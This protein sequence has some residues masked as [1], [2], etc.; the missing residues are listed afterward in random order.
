MLF[1]QGNNMNL[2]VLWVGF[3][4]IFGLP[5]CYA[6][7]DERDVSA[8]NSFYAALGSPPLPGWILNG[9]DP[10]VENWQ[11]VQCV[12]P[13]ITAIVIN[14]ANLG[15]QLGDGLGNFSSIIT[16]DL[17]NNNIGGDIPESLPLTLRTFFLSANQFTGSIPSSLSNLTLLT[18]MS[19]N[20]N[21]LTGDLPDAFSSL[22]GLINLDLSFNNLSGQLPA[23]M[24]N[25]SSLTTLRVQNNQFSGMLNVLEDLSVKDLNIENNLFSGP[26]PEKLLNIPNFKKDGNPFNTSIAP[27]L[28]PPQSSPSPPRSG[29]PPDPGTKHRNSSDGSSSQSNPKTENERSTSTLKIIAY[30]VVSVILV[31][32]FVLM[33]IFCLSKHQE[34]K[35]KNDELLKSQ[36]GRAGRG[37]FIE[38]K[39]EE[40]YAKTNNM[41][42]GIT[43]ENHKEKRKEYGPNSTMAVSDNPVEEEHKIDVRETSVIMPPPHVEKVTVQPIVLSGNAVGTSL[44]MMNSS[45]T[46][47][48]SFSVAELQQCTNS[49]S[50][51]NLIRDGMFGKVY[52]AEFPDGKLLEVMKLDNV[53]SRMPV[54]EFLELVLTLSELR[55]PNIA[56]LVGYCAEFDQRLLVYKYFSR[57]SLHD[58][59]HFGD[60]VIG[61]LSWSARL[62][63]ALGAAKGLE[64]LHE[65]CQP[66]IVHR[67]FEPANILLND[68]VCVIE[69]GLSSLMSFNSVAQLSG[70]IRALYSYQAPEI[71]DSG[72]C[73]DRSDVYSFGVV[74]LELLTGRKPYDSTLPRAEQHLVRWASSQLYDINALSRMVDPSLS[75]RYPEK[76]LSC[77]AD[78]ISR[79][80]QQ[81]PEFRPPISEIVQDLVRMI[82]DV[83][84]ARQ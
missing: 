10:C 52:L 38:P 81:E 25:L 50:E 58:I 40:H 43:K 73:T 70:R 13:N 42:T 57:K 79:C 77:F 49:F 3:M 35:S 23:S 15:G 61:K 24:G 62:E 56:E 21:H 37:G 63:V 36:V 47:A 22:T 11:G 66:P 82:K 69:C 20:N 4:V 83:K 12:G 6:F 33:V 48:T 74:M 28:A 45:A 51:E 30:V 41:V 68:A 54:D 44:K 60:N 32:V 8:I 29:A 78:I 39:N 31:I 75:G 17:S 16:I 67:N 19:V 27:S 14:G 84:V 76:S 5:Y 64:Y 80:I 53:N 46:S 2:K 65:D 18:D 34:R 26:I 9:G 72:H 55:H 71:N 7:T 1:F 59:L